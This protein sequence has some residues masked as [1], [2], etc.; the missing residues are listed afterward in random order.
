[1]GLEMQNNAAE[2]KLRAERRAGEMLDGMD[3]QGKGRPQKKS[4]RVTFSPIKL[5]EI[6]VTKKQSS[7]WQSIAALPKKDFEGY[8]RDNRQGQKEITTAG[9]LKLCKAREESRPVQDSDFPIAR[10]KN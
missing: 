1:M 10:W 8:I 4:H 6:G 3:R 5:S 9:A 2:I 7:R